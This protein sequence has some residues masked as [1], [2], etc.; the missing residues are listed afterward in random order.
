MAALAS[1]RLRYH[2]EGAVLLAPF[3]HR[4]ELPQPPGGGRTRRDLDEGALTRLE[5][6]PALAAHPI[7]E[8]GHAGDGGR[9]EDEVDRRGAALDRALMKL[10]HAA[11]HTDDELGFLRLEQAKLAE[12]REH[13]VL[14]L[15]A[16]RAGVDENQVGFGLI[17]GQLPALLPEQAGHSLR[18]VLVHLAA[19]CNQVELSHECL[20]NPTF[21]L[22]PTVAFAVGQV[23]RERS[24]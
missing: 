8:L 20:E 9:A 3:H 22:V 17:G 11:H 21:A 16:D 19:V 1:A 18:V 23:K 24:K 5:H 12:L 7:D 10:R 2:A 14:G 6:G 4:H 13:L 15:L